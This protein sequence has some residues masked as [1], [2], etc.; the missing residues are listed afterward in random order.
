[1]PSSHKSRQRLWLAL[2]AVGIAHADAMS[3]TIRTDGVYRSDVQT[4]ENQT[5]YISILRFAPDGRVFLIQAVMPA[6]QERVCERFR[7]ELEQPH[8]G[9]GAA[10]RL[11]S[12]RLS[13][14]TTSLNATTSFDGTVAS[15]TLQ[16]KLVVPTRQN[17]TYALTFKFAP[18]ADQKPAE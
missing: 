18:C 2:L 5:D 1:M 10:F 7:P 14:Q 11:E 16:L 8:W 3:E 6:R 12:D 17:L 9:K 13:F 4:N 15:D